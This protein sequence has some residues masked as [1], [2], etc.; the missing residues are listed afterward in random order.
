[1]F[2]ELLLSGLVYAQQPTL[3]GIP[4]DQETTISIKKGA[5]AASKTCSRF[6]IIKGDAEIAGEAELLSK[7]ARGAW[8]KACDEWKKETKELNAENR[9]ISLNCG[10]PE[11]GKM[12]TGESQCSSKGTYQ[13]RVR[14]EE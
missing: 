14:V 8:K 6:E 12:P 10:V 1:M 13:V 3:S 7:P 4:T 11:C 2:I 9:L 5:Q